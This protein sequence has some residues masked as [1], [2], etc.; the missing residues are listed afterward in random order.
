MWYVLEYKKSEKARKWIFVS[1]SGDKSFMEG[2]KSEYENNGIICQIRE[3][4]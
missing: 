4:A 3:Q 2:L 1:M